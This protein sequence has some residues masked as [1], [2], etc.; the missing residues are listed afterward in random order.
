M[1]KESKKK[2][3]RKRKLTQKDTN[4]FCE[5]VH[6]LKDA[7]KVALGSILRSFEDNG[8]KPS[9]VKKMIKKSE[10][11]KVKRS[12]NSYIL[13]SKKKRP[14]IKKNNPSYTFAEL[15]KAVSKEWKTLGVED[16]KKYTSKALNEK[17]EYK[18][19]TKKKM[20]KTKVAGMAD[21]VPKAS[22]KK[23]KKDQK[24]EDK[25]KTV[26]KVQKASR[27]KQKKDQTKED[28]PYWSTLSS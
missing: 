26:D 10:K 22:K 8:F 5:R 1:V 25:P 14:E 19:V 15:S 3:T 28:Q 23:Q 6:M 7:Q 4:E 12:P 16:K 9:T 20:N 24:K 11:S 27:K 17:N 2:S 21:E 13:F 18:K